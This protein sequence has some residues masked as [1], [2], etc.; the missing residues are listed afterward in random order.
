MVTS[1]TLI[2]NHARGD[3]GALYSTSGSVLQLDSCAM[4]RNS[5]AGEAG[6]LLS[7]GTLVL[8]DTNVSD[9]V[10]ETGGALYIDGGADKDSTLTRCVLTNNSATASGGA[11]QHEQG[12]LR[13]SRCELSSNRAGTK[14]GAIYRQ[15][16]SLLELALCTLANNSASG[17]AELSD[18]VCACCHFST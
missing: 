7:Y 11:I 9:C 4:H 10:A 3:G 2:D 13:L 16:G 12:E 14:G 17:R 6:A 18:C 1:S 15:G 8:V 5:A